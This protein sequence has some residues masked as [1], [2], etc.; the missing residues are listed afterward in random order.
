[1]A[2]RLAKNLKAQPRHTP[3]LGQA[4]QGT[5]AQKNAVT[6]AKNNEMKKV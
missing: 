5:K 4:S 6:L 2:K 3:A 1:L